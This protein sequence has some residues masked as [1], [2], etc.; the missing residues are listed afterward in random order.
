MMTTGATVTV[1]APREHIPLFLQGGHIL[2][3]QDPANT[4][5]FR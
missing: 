2:P 5:V 1:D 3:V 4:T